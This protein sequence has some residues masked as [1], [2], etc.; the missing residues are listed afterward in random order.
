MPRPRLSLLPAL[1]ALLLAAC[2]GTEGVGVP[3]GLNAR[4]V[5]LAQPVVHERLLTHALA[6]QPGSAG[7]A[8]GAADR[9]VEFLA[10]NGVEPGAQVAVAMEPA[11]TPALTEQRRRAAAGLL[12]GLGLVPGGVGSAGG[13]GAGDA[14]LLVVRQLQLTQ[15]PGCAGSA[16]VGR[17]VK[18]NEVAM[19]RFGCS[20]AHNLGL[21]LANPADLLA[22]RPMGPADGERAA[23]L[24]RSYKARQHALDRD[25]TGGSAGGFTPGGSD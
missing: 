12:T 9:L 6:F 5:D 17:I 19:S 25:D 4:R 10:F 14:A 15:P 24:L 11:A 23:L 20:T 18:D 13:S 21:M 1:A 8:P 7:L 3:G 22:A 2:Q 16:A